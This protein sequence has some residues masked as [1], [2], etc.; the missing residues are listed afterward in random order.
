MQAV[1]R[2][3]WSWV[4]YRVERHFAAMRRFSSLYE[5]SG[6]EV[7]PCREPRSEGQEAGSRSEV[8]AR[9][10]ILVPPTRR[11]RDITIQNVHF[12]HS[13]R[14]AV[15]QPQGQ[16]QATIVRFPLMVIALLAALWCIGRRHLCHPRSVRGLNQ[17]N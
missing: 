6:L 16:S 11:W 15:G 13:H 7:P 1:P 4:M 2:T 12:G 8:L 17:F 3:G 10:T 14:C 9:P 5:S